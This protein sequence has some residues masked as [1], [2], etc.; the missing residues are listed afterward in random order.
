MYPLSDFEYGMVVGARRAGLSISEIA[1]LPGLLLSTL[2]RVYR[3]WSERQKIFSEWQ[4]CGWKC[5]VSAKGQKIM[6]RL[7]QADRMATVKQARSSE[8]HLWALNM[9]NLEADGLQQQNTYQCH[10]CQTR[11]AKTKSTVQM[12]S[13]KLDNRRLE[14]LCLVWW[15]SISA[16][17]FRW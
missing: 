11:T 6:A 10:S 13:P 3:E 8:E 1:D 16:A 15:V 12:G 7:V 9:S 14:K 2:F 17:T 5:L 4:I